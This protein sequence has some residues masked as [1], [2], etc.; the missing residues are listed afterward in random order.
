MAKRA[1][2]TREQKLH[3]A[4][5]A[6]AAVL[7]A[8][9]VGA[10]V[11]ALTRPLPP[12]A[13]PELPAPGT[14]A[15]QAATP[16][17]AAPGAVASQTPTAAVVPTTPASTP[18]TGTTVVAPA[19]RRI[20]FHLGSTLY[21]ASEDGK[22]KT[23]MYLPGTDYALSPDGTTVA[24][25]DKGKFMMAAVGTHLLSSSPST[26]GL[27]AEAVRPVWT[28]DSSQALFVRAD[29]SGEPHVWVFKRSSGTTTDLGPGSGA[30]VSPDGSHVAL[31]PA[32]DT[33]RSITILPLAGG[34]K[35]SVKLTS[36]D[37]VAIALGTKRL[38][39]STLSAAGNSSI[40][41]FDYNGANK[42]RL[43][44]SS[45]AS[46]TAVT[47]GNLMLSPS[48]TKVLFSADGDDGYSRL[49]TVPAIGG[50]ASKLSGRRDGYPLGWTRDGK[51]VLFIEGNAFQGQET[52]LW[53]SDLTGTK[54]TK[55]V[56]GATL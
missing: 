13:L 15:S 4:I 25:I 40:W 2:R 32:D 55:L 30:A 16:T 43:V 21:L 1:P 33:S 28:P 56:E 10:A 35:T 8:V 23:P 53:R 27:A 48:G 19:D 18:A 46:D 7:A 6:A 11:W 37:P 49:W 17:T 24:A 36:G 3:A 39:V 52:A 20:G 34:S 45:V 44:D 5:V 9:M 41:A 42:K 51:Y 29:K 50:K 47:Y 31:L 54:R 38:F 26:P 22:N 12:G 14:E